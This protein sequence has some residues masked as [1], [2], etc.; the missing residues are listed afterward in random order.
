MT[1]QDLNGHLDMV[2]QLQTARELLGN[3]QARILGAQQCDGMPH[4]HIASRTTE[5]LAAALEAQYAEVARLERIVTNSETEVKA[6]IDTIN[7]TRTKLIF[8][9]RFLCGC[10]WDDVATMLGVSG[11]SDA[12]KMACYRYVDPEHYF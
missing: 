10:K 1:L 12:V 8:R 7:D 9:L 5:N 6:F 2:L 3:M 11:T 4:A